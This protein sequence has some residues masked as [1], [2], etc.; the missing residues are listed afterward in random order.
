MSNRTLHYSL[1]YGSH[2]IA[3]VIPDKTW[4]GM[5]RVRTPEGHLSDMANL[6]RAKDAAFVMTQRGPP[7]RNGQ[8]LRWKKAPVGDAQKRLVVSPT[9]QDGPLPTRAT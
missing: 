7:E 5:W 9:Q 1:R 8:H 2:P 3:E 6:T 4:P